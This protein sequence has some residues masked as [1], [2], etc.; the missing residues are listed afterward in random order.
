SLLP[1]SILPI[2]SRPY[3]P[4][5][6]AA[7][8]GVGAERDDVPERRGCAVVALVAKAKGIEAGRRRRGRR[9]P[10]SRRTEERADI[11]VFR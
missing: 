7:A 10:R 11:V 1:P 2:R 4:S 3:N 9:S 5:P 6:S 8:P